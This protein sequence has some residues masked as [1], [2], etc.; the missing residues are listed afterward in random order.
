MLGLIVAY[1]ENRVI[2]KDGMIPWRIKGEQLRFK[3][4]TTGNVVIMGRRSYEEIGRPLPNRTTIVISSTKNFDQENCYTVK[5]LQ[6]AIL[7]A[8]ER[9]AY[10]S[11]GA[12]VYKEALPYVDKMY[13][14]EIHK[15]IEGDTYFP[16]F[17]KEEWTKEV[18]K[19]VDG[20]I[21]YTYVTYTRKK[22]DHSDEEKQ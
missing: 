11:G 1:A 4:L 14:T 17:D 10:I 3:E 18:E 12:G 5:S 21:P 16:E 6:E 8:G 22:A 7:L 13:I 20:E 2:G 9:D 15:E 19:E